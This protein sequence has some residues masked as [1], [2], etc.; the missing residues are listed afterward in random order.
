MNEA[1]LQQSAEAGRSA[2]LVAEESPGDEEEVDEEIK[3]DGG[4]AEAGPGVS[5]GA[6]VEVEVGFA[7][8]TE[9]EAVGEALGSEGVA[10]ERGQLEVEADGEE[11][12]KGEVEGVGPE[13][14]REATQR[15]GQAV[16]EDVATFVHYAG[17]LQRCDS[18]S[19][20]NMNVEQRSDWNE[21][22]HDPGEELCCELVED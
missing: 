18:K 10:E 4:V 5:D 21:C 7:E 15:E 19:Y 8:G 3:E 2:G 20:G 9:V 17:P 13:K 6:F 22:L 11:E 14:R 16:E 12:R 1:L